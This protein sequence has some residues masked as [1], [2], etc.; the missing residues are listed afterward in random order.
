MKNKKEIIEFIRSEI[1]RKDK[2]QLDQI[3]KEFQDLRMKAYEKRIEELEK[4][5]LTLRHSL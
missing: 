1:K 5:I 2:M 3:E 4:E